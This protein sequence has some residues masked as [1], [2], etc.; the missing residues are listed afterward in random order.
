MIVLVDR[1]NRN[2]LHAYDKLN[3]GFPAGFLAEYLRYMKALSLNEW[4]PKM[5]A[6]YLESDGQGMENNVQTPQPFNNIEKHRVLMRLIDLYPSE[7]LIWDDLK[8]A[9]YELH[10]NGYKIPEQRLIGNS[11]ILWPSEKLEL[12]YS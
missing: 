7:V 12:Q 10:G 8:D 3:N 6:I 4:D 1:F 11:E 5:A 9:Y 2:V